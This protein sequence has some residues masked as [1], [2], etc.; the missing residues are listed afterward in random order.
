MSLEIIKEKIAT[1]LPIEDVIGEVV[2]LKKAGQRRTGCCP[3]HE[4]KTPSFHVF[5]DHYHCFGCGAHGDTIEFVKNH[6]GFSFIDAVK[7]LAGKAGIDASSLDRRRNQSEWNKEKRQRELVTRANDFFI[8]QLRSPAGK[9]AVDYLLNRGFTKEQIET[10]GFGF[11]PDSRNDLLHI[12]CAQGYKEAEIANASLANLSQQGKGYD[13]FQ[14]RVLVPI[15]NQHGTLIAFGG[16]TLGDSP[17]KYKNSRYDKRT[18]LFGLHHAREHIRKA[19]YAI[20]V[21]GYM[22]ALSLWAQGFPQTVAC[23]GTSLTTDHLN[24]LRRCTNKAILMF[25]GDKAGKNASLRLV[26]TALQFSD[27]S[28]HVATL[29]EG[30]DPDS[31]VRNQGP[32]ALQKLCDQTDGLLSYAIKEHLAGTE[33]INIPAKIREDLLP[34]VR[35]QSDSLSRNYL[36]GVI[37]KISGIRES[38]I[39]AELDGTL[40]SAIHKKEQQKQREKE[41]KAETKEEKPVILD[42]NTNEL[43]PL[44]TEFLLQFYF[45]TPEE[46]TIETL[47]EGVPDW[48]QLTPAW[49]IFLE[50]L[51]TSLK[52][53]KTPYTLPS[54]SWQGSQSAS[55]NAWLEVVSM[56]QKGY[57]NC[58]REKEILR[59]KSRVK[60]KQNKAQ[61]QRLKAQLLSMSNENYETPADILRAISHLQKEQKALTIA[62]SK[63]QA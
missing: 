44:Q 23:Q 15:H 22:D 11:A 36:C 62:M 20:V 16:R 45:A 55:F 1:S 3:F 61:V 49:A 57:A 46:Y 26:D 31:Y 37:A 25:D 63:K 29:P 40:N 27:I 18:V 9:K 7:H 6:Y 52:E 56:K 14:D 48:L 41:L 8:E 42:W 13:F 24:L 10:F 30:S 58:D 33:A 35:A 5:D 28:L 21:E 2:S 12:L 50:E 47:E 4:E 51:Q 43:G 32:E 17:Q 38:V 39:Q 34:W 54:D 19:G 53:Q 59:I 60:F